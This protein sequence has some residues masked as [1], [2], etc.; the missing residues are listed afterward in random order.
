MNRSGTRRARRVVARAAAVVVAAGL[1]VACVPEDGKSGGSGGSG[2][3]GTG[4]GPGASDSQKPSGKP[5][6]EPGGAGKPG[7]KEPGGGGEDASKGPGGGASKKPGGSPDGVAKPLTCEMLRN[8]RL[9]S[10]SVELPF[11]T[12]GAV[13]TDGRWEGDGFVIELQPQC[14][15]GDVTGDEAQDAVGVVKMSSSGT[16]RFYALVTWRNDHGTA[17]PAA[18][19]ELG[20]RTPVVSVDVPA[21]GPRGQVTVVYRTRGDDDPP[22]IVTLTRTAVYEVAE[23]AMRELHHSDAPYTP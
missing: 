5:G 14:A 15:V 19:A 1:M 12:P 13:L 10:G 23:P 2:G 16:G 17:V 4:E 22:A 18:T 8:S 3:S 6:G 9:Q 21:S 7:G 11:G 20:D